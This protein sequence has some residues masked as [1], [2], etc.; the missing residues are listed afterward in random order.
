MPGYHKYVFDR[1]KRSFV[2]RF[3]EM[4]EAEESE[5]FDS[6]FERDLRPLRK[7]I[8]Q[9]ILNTC[10]FSRILDVGYG[11]GTFTHLMKKQNNRVVGIDVSPAAIQKAK[12]SFPDVEFR[13]MDAHDLARLG[14]TFGLVVVMGTFAYVDGWPSVV[15]TIADMTRWLYVAEYIPPNPIGFVKS[16]DDLINAVEKQFVI[17]TRVLLDEVNCLL[18]AEVPH[19]GSESSGNAAG[20]HDKHALE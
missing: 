13:C 19:A 5:G 2:G 10:Q 14:E 3:D 6:W 15:E 17:R 20:Q 1:D 4:Y 8:S 18:F 12:Q 7:T 11:K 9:A 16:V